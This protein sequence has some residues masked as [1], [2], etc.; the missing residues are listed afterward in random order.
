MISLILAVIFWIAGFAVLTLG[1]VLTNRLR[2]A[3]RKLMM[4]A[5]HEKGKDN[6]ASIAM[7]IEGS[8]LNHIP[9]FVIHVVTGV[10]GAIL[11]AFGC[12][13]LGFY[14]S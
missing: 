13:A 3:G 5:E 9:S 11:F 4:R 2:T 1:F 10:T 6:S 7:T 14:V 8:A 12:V